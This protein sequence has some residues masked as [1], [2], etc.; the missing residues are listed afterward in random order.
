MGKRAR[1]S[2]RILKLQSR[3]LR[4]NVLCGQARSRAAVCLFGRE[5]ASLPVARLL[6]W[7][8]QSLILSPCVWGDLKLNS[9]ISLSL[10]FTHTHVHAHAHART[11]T[12]TE[13][14]Y[15][16]TIGHMSYHS[17]TKHTS[18]SKRTT[19]NSHLPDQALRCGLSYSVSV[20]PL[21]KWRL[22]Q[23]S[24]THMALCF[25]QPYC[26]SKSWYCRNRFSLKVGVLMYSYLSLTLALKMLLI[27]GVQTRS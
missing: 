14:F 23:S 19:Y 21:E 16:W 6:W 10:S 22:S 25:L 11:H 5:G 9:R 18:P 3:T 7:E 24:P 8:Q 12:H 2:I 27:V 17:P 20:C 4:R 1:N 13:A 26:L 15:H